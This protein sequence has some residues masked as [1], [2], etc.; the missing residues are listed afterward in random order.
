MPSAT[1]HVDVSAGWKVHA[2]GARHNPVAECPPRGVW[3]GE[4]RKT[5][6]YV[7]RRGPR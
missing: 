6:I 4:W 5:R 2:C 1:P 7:P 3:L